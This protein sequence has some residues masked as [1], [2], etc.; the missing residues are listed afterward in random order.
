M[1]PSDSVVLK[2]F[3]G[4]GRWL[5]MTGR[6]RACPG[7]LDSSGYSVLCARG[8]R[9]KPG[10]DRGMLFET[11]EIRCRLRRAASCVCDP[12]LHSMCRQNLN[13]GGARWRLLSG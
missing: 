6:G 11:I 8:R 12:V 13:E 7:H 4:E 1:R 9:D 10:D 2:R 5:N 3:P